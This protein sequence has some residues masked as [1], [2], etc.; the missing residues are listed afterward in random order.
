MLSALAWVPRG[1]AKAMPTTAEPTEE[2]LEAA[3]AALAARGDDRSEDGDEEEDEEEGGSDSDEG[4]DDAAEAV[5]GAKA[6]A[7]AIQGKRKNKRGAAAPTDAIEA[8]L[9]ELDMDNYD[10]EDDVG[11]VAR[12]LGGLGDEALDEDG[13]P[14]ITLPDG[15]GGTDS[16]DEDYEIKPTDLLILAARHEDDVSNLEVWVYE[17]TDTSGAANVYVHHDILLP[18]FP[19]C[20]AWM[21]CSPSGG[22]DKANMC[23][24]GT[25]EP[26][27]DIWDIDVVD[28]VEP[29]ATLGGEDREAT[30]A[31]ASSSGGDKKKK[32]KKKPSKPVLRDGSHQDAVLG[33]SWNQ[34]YRNVLASGSADQTVK[35]WDVSRQV[36]KHTLTHHTGKVQAVAWNPAEASVLLTGA[37]DRTACLV[38]VRTPNGTPPSWA[39]SADVEALTWHPH[40]PTCFLVSSEDGVVASYDARK[41]AGSAPVFVLAAHD[42]ATCTMSFSPSAPGLLATG[43]TDKKVKLWDVRND[44]PSLV[45]SQDLQIGAVFSASF[46]GQAGYLLACCGAMGS[47][48]V[49]DMRLAK[50]V[51][52]RWPGIMRMGLYPDSVAASI[53]TV[54]AAEGGDSDASE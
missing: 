42:A 15:G 10:N 13:D 8:G 40:Q 26:G 54:N 28:S 47:V 49:W 20:V 30:A 39:I 41:G 3:R 12:L 29:A 7:A 1:A 23:A 6:A 46:C 9:R 32:K 21:D 2:E 53:A 33:L 52:S 24:V 5:R 37:F 4:M 36:A 18:S 45:T 17:E 43:S 25:L 44:T 34:Q 22:A 16:E 51:G 48:S 35:V 27:I 31:A 50:G 11:V 14:Y 38:D 19:L